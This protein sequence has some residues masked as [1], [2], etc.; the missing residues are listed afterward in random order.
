MQAVRVC[1]VSEIPAAQRFIDHLR[2]AG[3]REWSGAAIPMKDGVLVVY[4]DAH[5]HTRIRATLMEE[6]FHLRLGHPPSIVRVY[7][8]AGARRSYD[9]TVE[10]DAYAS[11]A[12]TLV[13]YVA[14]RKAIERGEPVASIGRSLE[15]SPALVEYRLKVT[16]LWARRVRRAASRSAQ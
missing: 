1:A 3:S 13:P 6:Y 5:P 11:G 14:L 4:N 15:V 12:A 8:E 10:S 9:A 7:V 16:K 2:G